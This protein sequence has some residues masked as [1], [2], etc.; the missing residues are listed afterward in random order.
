MNFTYDII[1]VGGGHAG[2]EAARMAAKMGCKTLLITMD[3]TKMAQMS[4]NP[5]MGGIAKGQII[6]EIDALG[7]ASGIVTDRTMVQ[8]RMLN[9]SKGPAMWSPRAQCDRVLFS[10][11]WRSILETTENLFIWQDVALRLI[12]EE[13]RIKG[14]I[15][16]F[17]TSFFSKAVILTNGTFLNG[18]MHVGFNKQAGGRSGEAASMGLS[19]QLKELG[20]SVER[21]KTGTSA[22]IDG[23]SI[24]FKAMT[25]QKGDME[26]RCFSYT[27]NRIDIHNELSCFI[28]Y[29]NKY[30]HDI[31]RA[32]LEFSPLYTGRIKG[33][34]PRYCPSIETKIVTFE[35]KSLHQLFIEPEGWETNEYYINGFSSSL[36]LDIQIEALKIVPGLENV[37]IYR[38]G[39]AIEYDFFQ[40]TQLKN[41]L[42]TKIIESLYFAGQINGTT[43]YEEA[44]A[45]GLIAG[46]NAALKIT[47]KEP[48]V[49]GRDQAYI[50]V[51][52]D[53]LVTKGVDEPYRMFTSRA[54]Y[55]ILLRQDN[56]DERLTLLAY[57]KG[58]TDKQALERLEEKENAIITLI[59]YLE[60]RSVA[61]EEINN[62]LISIETGTIDQKVRGKSLASRPQ[63]NL[64]QMLEIL[65]KEKNLEC[66]SM[67]E[68]REIIES[69]EIRIKYSGYIDREK[70]VAEKIKR[71]EKLKIPIDIDYSELAS[72]STEG[73]QKLKRIKPATI[74]QATRISGVSSSDISILIMYLGR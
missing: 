29:T 51:L 33:V 22:R 73:R 31:L 69:A 17:G 12:V 37:T 16:A 48:L 25:E 57:K 43:G 49:L 66:F 70:N 46:A 56:A 71:L 74:G 11:E 13:N 55:R 44:A 27:N 28:T 23:R 5:A 61:P 15:T 9:R 10:R 52:I 4:C 39:Y 35:G 40:P 47:E 58:M 60:E 63:V 45:Q 68:R 67:P 2:C 1:V 36:P 7:G 53:D 38:P 32:G 62:Y 14:I 72:I 24:N 6:R 8:F 26:G 50:G 41:T 3:M 30:V 65:D 59:Q 18:M 20:F 21:M 34:G 64:E 19:E 42:E 54:E